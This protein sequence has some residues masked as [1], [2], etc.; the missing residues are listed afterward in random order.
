AEGIAAKYWSSTVNG[1]SADN[2]YINVVAFPGNTADARAMGLPV[3]CI[4]D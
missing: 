4:K 1:T 2:L 3:R